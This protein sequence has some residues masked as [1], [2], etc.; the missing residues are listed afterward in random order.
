MSA[1]RSKI[2][3]LL[4]AGSIARA[5]TMLAGG[6]ALGQVVV[7]LA[8]PLTTWLY[9][10]T[11]FG[12]LAVYSSIIGIVATVAGLRLE[13][14]LPLP[15][16]DDTAG[17][18]LTIAFAAVVGV[19]ILLSLSMRWWGLFIVKW[20]N[21]PSLQSYLWIVPLGV[22]CTGNYNNLMFWAT[23]HK[24]FGAIGKTK[25]RQGTM[26]A[27]TQIIMGLFIKNPLGLLLGMVVGHSAGSLSL[28]HSALFELK[29]RLD[30][31]FF[32]RVRSVL[33]R[34]K[35]FP[36]LIAPSSLLDATSQY[37]PALLL[38][39]FFGQDVSGSYLLANRLISLPVALIGRAVAQVFLGE[40][41]KRK[42]ESLIGFRHL[43]IITV[44]KL[45]LLALPPV[46]ML[47]LMAPLAFEIIFP[48]RWRV[49]ADYI[50][51]L[52]P[53]LLLGL[54]ASPVSQT[55]NILEQ[56]ALHSLWIIA[57]LF[58]V[59]GSLWLSLHKGIGAHGAIAILGFTNFLAYLLHITLCMLTMNR[60]IK[61]EEAKSGQRFPEAL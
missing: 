45:F 29:S 43:Y 35:H 21:T 33:I 9:T 37:L 22:F 31:A 55:L 40:G 59:V 44:R 16:D 2:R 46:G 19:A 5:I 36:L 6:T 38:A 28:S 23:R 15:D 10:P 7:I 13:L 50:C 3:E 57:R 47:V 42:R 52:S 24:Q 8:M 60:L 53:M 25:I 61:M 39:V 30:I 54:V 27:L 41:A 32:R 14:A 20:T 56:Q 26:L 34:Y 1:L 11:D 12:T 48:P 17:D 51:L 18:L 4:P 58:L 49:A